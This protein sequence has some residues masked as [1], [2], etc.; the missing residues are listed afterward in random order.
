LS[1]PAN[2]AD[3]ARYGAVAAVNDWV[4]HATYNVIAPP[5]A[6]P[7]DGGFSLQTNPA[8]P[9]ASPFG[10]H[11]TNGAAGAEFT[12]TRGNN[13]DSH[14]DRNDDDIADP[15]PGRPNG[16]ASLDFSSYVQDPAQAPTVLQNQNVAQVNLFLHQQHRPRHSL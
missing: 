5:N 3:R 11:D 10:W 2:A 4:D 8:D 16:G 14:L 6:S 15:S 13:V 1:V 9:L 12:D 7:Q